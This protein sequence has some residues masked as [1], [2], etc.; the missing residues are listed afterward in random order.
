MGDGVSRYA[1]RRESSPS[2]CRPA[3]IS[4]LSQPC[5]DLSKDRG[6]SP[7]AL[8]L[9]DDSSSCIAFLNVEVVK[10]ERRGR[11]RHLGHV[12]APKRAH[13]L[14]ITCSEP[15]HQR[16]LEQLENPSSNIGAA[17]TGW[18]ASTTARR[19]RIRQ[20]SVHPLDCRFTMWL[21]LLW[22]DPL[23]AHAQ[24]ITGG[25]SPMV[26][27]QKNW[28]VAAHAVLCFEVLSW[29]CGVSTNESKRHRHTR[30]SS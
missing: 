21:P 24:R 15:A 23:L 13:H 10:P 9:P 2:P 17:V 5:G 11:L 30:T 16:L 25:K 8:Y 22:S 19:H 14:S 20:T 3:K 12:C 4:S 27:R 1:Q 18:R 28:G 6:R 29:D 26:F 7:R